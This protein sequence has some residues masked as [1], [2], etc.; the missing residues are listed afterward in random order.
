MTSPQ[1]R[2]QLLQR[3]QRARLPLFV[4]D[5]AGGLPMPLRSLEEIDE[6]DAERLV[7]LTHLP[8]LG[9]AVPLQF[10]TKPPHLIREGLVRGRARQEPPYP[11]HEVGS[12]RRSY[13][14]RL[15]QK[16]AELLQ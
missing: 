5:G 15:E 12:R 7:C 13:Q 3:R 6:V 4:H 16:L 14:L 10:L 2:P 11:A 1:A 8:V 9:S